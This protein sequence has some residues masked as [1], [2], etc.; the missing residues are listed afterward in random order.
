MAVINKHEM[1]YHKI[2]DN[3]LKGEDCSAFSWSYETGGVF[4]FNWV[5]IVD[6]Q[7]D[8]ILEFVHNTFLKNATKITQVN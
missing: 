4:Y 2:H 6:N 3:F 7:N 8:L 5:N 1:L